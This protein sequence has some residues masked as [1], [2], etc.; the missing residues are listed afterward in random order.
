VRIRLTIAYDGTSFAGW[1]SQAAGDSVQDAIE[2]AL[3]KIAKTKIT[4][5]GAGRTDA[6]VHA[7]GQ[8]AHFDP[9]A[10]TRLSPVEWQR[11]LNGNLPGTVR[12]LR[13]SRAKADFHA[14]F[15]ARGK[16]YR[17]EIH[18]GPVLPPAEF[19]RAWHVPHEL[20]VAR[21]R[22]AVALFVGSHDFHAFSANRGNLPKS[23]VRRIA[24]ARVVQAGP[25]LAVTFEG[26]GFLY[27]MV[28]MLVGAGV[29]VGQGR[30]PL[31]QITARLKDPTVGRWSFVAPADGLHL[32][33]VLY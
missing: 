19:Q 16:I 25:R 2:R 20:D 32:V 28:R 17:Y 31:A 5:H 11:A 9:P 15:S 12:V 14:R 23:T 1:Q 3:A 26:D 10:T 18:L 33:R 24:S 27:K 22:K 30:E 29:R 8:S 6:G 4:L 7:L 13:A 21:L